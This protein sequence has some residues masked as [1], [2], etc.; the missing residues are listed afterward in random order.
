MIYGIKSVVSYL[1]GTD[2][3]GRNLAVFPDD[4]FIVSYPRSGNTWTRFLIANLMH[5]EEPITFANIERVIPD[6][7]ALSSKA[8]K[9]VPRPRLLKSHEY[10]DPRYQKAVYLVRDP[11][12]VAISLYHFRRKY[13]TIDDGYPIERYVVERFLKGDMDVSWGE[14]VGSWLGARGKSPGFLLVRYE[15]LLE[16]PP[17]ELRRLAGFLGI[18]VG[19]ERVALA[20]ERSGADRLRK[21]E[22]AEHEQWVTTKGKRPDIPF[23]GAGKSGGWKSS[24]PRGSAEQ[25]E[26]AWGDLMQSLGYELSG[27][28][29]S[30][31]Q[32]GLAVVSGRSDI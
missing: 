32:G 31:P 16:D 28:A 11:R 5:A 19:S 14:H 23:I 2:I 15:D 20:I 18:D 4:S 25:I 10:F 3:A 29:V 12:D 9:K 13:R 8:L 7:S 27:Q 1:L 22:K 24:L 30:S 21:L 17:R 26:S 6:T